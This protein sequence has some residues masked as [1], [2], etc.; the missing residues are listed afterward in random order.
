MIYENSQSLV[1][2]KANQKMMML[3]LFGKTRINSFNKVIEAG[4]V[5]VFESAVEQDVIIKSALSDVETDVLVIIF[6][7]PVS[8]N[9]YRVNTIDLEIRNKLNFIDEG[10]NFPGF[11]GIFDGREEG[12]YLL[13]KSSHKIFAIV[14]NGAFEFQNRLMET[15]DAILIWDIEELEFEALSEDALILFFEF[16]A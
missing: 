16:P 11:I 5:V 9:S 1:N 12:R 3:P 8:E 13:K 2:L 6:N 10:F 7:K 14:I 4:E 15:R